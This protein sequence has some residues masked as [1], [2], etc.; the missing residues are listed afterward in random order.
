MVHRK[1][2]P[3]LLFLVAIVAAGSL[4]ADEQENAGQEK[5]DQATEIKISAETAGDL[6]DVITLCREAIQEGLDEANKSFANDLLSSTLTQRADLICMELFEQPLRPSRARRLVEMAMVDLQETLAIDPKQALPQYLIGRLY[7]HLGEKDKAL[8]A[9]DEAVRLS[10]QDPATQSQALL[11]RANL[12]DDP[13]QRTADFDKAVALTPHDP[14]VFRNR[15]M[16]HLADNRAEQAL[17]DFD[18]ALE[19]SPNDSDTHEARGLAQSVLQKYDDAMESFN[20]AIE[21]SPDSATAHTHRARVRAIKGDTP[22]ALKD[23]EQALELQPGSIQ[24][25]QLHATLLGSTGK[26]E[27]A[28]K[29]LNLLRTAMPNDPELLLQIAAL[30]QAS[31]QAD[32]AIETY[33]T[34][35]ESDPVNVSGYRGRADTYLSLGKQAEA[36]AD[37]DKALEHDPENSGVLNNLAWVLATSPQDNVRNGQRAIELATKACEVTEYKQAHILSTLAA[38]YAEAGDF[39]KAVEWSTKSV[40]LGADELKDHLR[41]EL[42]SYEAKKPWR[43]EIPPDLAA[44]PAELGDGSQPSKNETAR[45]KGGR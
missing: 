17:A 41:K 19:L 21:L 40:E 36:V 29:D 2:L 18:A 44:G 30:Y 42:Q 11:V 4:R 7:A 9:L 8:A 20:K 14:D 35:L 31:K 23:V 32:K 24:A 25:L 13:D 39:D 26:F 34:L 6:N 10:A 3:C 33:G 22:A 12:R 38:A 37:Y 27:K 1:F 15:G 45:S 43:E 28:L 5:L 16:Y